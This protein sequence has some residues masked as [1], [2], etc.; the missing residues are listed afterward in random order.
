MHS[1]HNKTKTI[2]KW[3]ILTVILISQLYCIFRSVYNIY[4]G[5]ITNSIISTSWENKDENITLTMER[6]N[7]T[8]IQNVYGNFKGYDFYLNYSGVPVC[9]GFERKSHEYMFD[10]TLTTNNFN[11]IVIDYLE[12]SEQYCKAID[13]PK[14][15]ILKRVN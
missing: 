10:A 3:L 4:S 13:A 7:L 9:E 12:L 15:I 14:Q 8:N 5:I 11:E 1:L 6:N 2:F